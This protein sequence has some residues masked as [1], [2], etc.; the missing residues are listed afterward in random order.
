MALPDEGFQLA[1]QGGKVG[2]LL[3]H[4]RKMLAGNRIDGLAGLVFV[5][6]KVSSARTRSMEEPK[7]VVPEIESKVCRQTGCGR[8]SD[9]GGDCLQRHAPR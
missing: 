2:E 5:I 4:L 7:R 1:T 3:L 6:G 9:P 8:T